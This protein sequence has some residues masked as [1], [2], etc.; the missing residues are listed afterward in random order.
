[1]VTFSHL[2][3]KNVTANFY[4]ISKYNNY[5]DYIFS[6]N[7]V[8]FKSSDVDSTSQYSDMTRSSCAHIIISDEGVG[9]LVELKLHL[10]LCF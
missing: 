3:I 10:M 7:A 4:V 2:N 1:M 6:N 9:L 8:Q 5:D